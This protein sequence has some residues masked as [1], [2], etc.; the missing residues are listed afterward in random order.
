MVGGLRCHFY[1][2][3]ERD[4]KL[5]CRFAVVIEV[6][7]RTYGYVVREVGACTPT[8]PT[9]S[10]ELVKFTGDTHEAG[11]QQPVHWVVSLVAKVTAKPVGKLS[12]SDSE[13]FM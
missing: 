13:T 9:F 5:D 3:A 8:L 6:A 12:G 1:L 4:T 2:L 7:L 10:R 11:F